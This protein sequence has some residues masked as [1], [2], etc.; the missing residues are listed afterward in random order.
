MNLENIDLQNIEEVSLFDENANSYIPKLHAYVYS[1]LD[2][3]VSCENVTKVIESVFKLCNKKAAK[4]PSVSTINNW[5]VERTLIARRHT[6]ETCESEN[7]TLHTD[8][9]SKYGSKWSA[10][11]TRNFEGNYMLLGLRDMTTKSSSDTLETFKEILS[12]INAA[13]EAE[14]DVG[15]KILCNIK[16]TMS[17]RAA[18]ETR[19]NALLK[20]YKESVRCC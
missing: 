15:K 1:L 7:T 19:F 8:E 3:H 17:D 11:A 2:C 10:F 14:T 6:S 16:N 12:D 20:D 4:L 13:S 18:M 5:S 9:A